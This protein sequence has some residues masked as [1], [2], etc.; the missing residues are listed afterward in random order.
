MKQI[1]VVAAIIYNSQGH[2]FATQR[3]YGEFK[4]Y[5]EFPGG[6]IEIDETP[7][8]ALKREIWEELETLIQVERLFETVEN[9][10]NKE[11][12]LRCT[13]NTTA[14]NGCAE[15]LDG[16]KRRG[17]MTA[18]LSNK[19]DEFVPRILQKVYPN[20]RFA[21]AWGQKPQYKTKPDG[22]A[23]HAILALHGVK[24]GEC[25]Y[26]GDSNV[27]VFTALEHDRAQLKLDETQGGE[28]AAWTC[29][30]DDDLGTIVHMRICD[31]LVVQLRSVLVNVETHGEVDVDVALT[32]I[33]A[34]LE[35]AQVT[36]ASRV[37]TGLVGAAVDQQRQSAGRTWVNAEL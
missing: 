17:I 27:D 28:K 30:D 22:E 10:F 24:P 26:I 32:G 8:E 20:H 12:A 25:V 4:D 9:T 11:Y 35:N 21:E 23:L 34:P 16:L 3:G 37:D 1:E 33:N 6:K 31:G 14:Y 7:E 36:D 5:W 18:V 2:I 19:P 29:S 15:L 13:D